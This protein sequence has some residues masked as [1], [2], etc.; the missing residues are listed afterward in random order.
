MIRRSLIGASL[1]AMAST[2]G[3]MPAL[4]RADIPLSVRNTFRIG[5]SGVICTAQNAPGDARLGG[6]FDRS[7]RLTC[8]D[9]AGAVGTLI[10]VHRELPLDGAPSA[11]GVPELACNV[12]AASLIDLVGAVSAQECRDQRSGVDY[13]RY[14]ARRDGVTYLVEGLAGY[15]PALRLALAS[16]VKDRSI[17]GEIRVASTEV[18]DPAAFARIQAG[19]L[20]SGGVREEAYLRNNGGHYAESAAFFE[21]LAER[22]EHKQAYTA[23]GIG[24]LAEALAS[25]ALQQSNMGN[26]DAAT[27]LFEASAKSISQGDVLTQRLLRNNRALDRL[28]QRDP[29]AAL[30]EIARPV[31]PV[32]AIFDR[33]KL[34]HGEI[35][36]PLSEQI[37]RENEVLKRLGGIDTGLSV[38]ERAAILDAQAVALSGTAA[39]LQGKFAD[40]AS[41]LDQADRTLASVHN[42][43]VVSVGWLRS[44]IAVETALVEEAQGQTGNAKASFDRAIAMLETAFPQSPALLAA[45]A[46]KAAFLGRIGAASEARTLFADVVKESASSGDSGVALRDLL[47]PYFRLLA[48]QGGADAATDAFAAAQVLQRPGVAQTQAVLAR[49]FAEG[50]DEASALFRLSLARTRD[51]VRSEGEIARL[52]GLAAP[53]PAELAQLQ[54]E[55]GQLVTLQ[56]DQTA[57]VSR[58]A[59]YPRYN[60]LSPQRVSLNELQQALKPG[61]AYYKLMVAGDEV[62]A[63]FA[64]PTA[65]QTFRINLSRDALADQVRNIRDTI[66][67]VE[68]GR[69][70]NYPFNVPLSRSL[71]RSLFD[72]LEAEMPNV[73]H[74]VFE[75]DGAML[76]LPPGVLIASDKGIAAY[77]RQ[78]AE[79]DGDPFDMTGIDWLG[80]NREISIA[81]SPRGFLDIRK[82]APSRAARPYLG[83][84]HNASPPAR[85]VTAAVAD[86]CDWPLATWQN[87]ISADELHFAQARMGPG[88]MVMT[89]GQFSDTMLLADPRLDQYRV[90]H[91][92]T[93]GLVTAPRKDCPARPA[94]ITSFGGSGSDGLLSFR[95][96]FDL[97]LDADVVIL[98]ACDTAGMATI[99]ASR[100]AGVTSGGNYALDGLVRAFVGSGARSVVASHWP[101][102]D[103]FDA[104]KRLIGGMVSA[105]PG[106]PLAEALMEA[107][108][109]LMNDPRTSHPFY[110]A[111][112]II[113]GDGAKPMIAD[114]TKVAVKFSPERTR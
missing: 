24:S 12:A 95:E 9:A 61:E 18:S 44:E 85:T 113:L 41:Q 94:L 10:A 105:I 2:L 19:Q 63:L 80:R 69:Q 109:K 77:T 15:D 37:N 91:F 4:A 8:R 73:R 87:P 22:D 67:K 7:Y 75:P 79:P 29:A 36:L 110:W 11:P 39:R 30:A 78:S 27:R 107:E 64:S 20:D 53:T 101:V 49:Q 71:Y 26:F 55:Q 42:G 92:A 58:L 34:A 62:Y 38:A 82:L 40:A 112:F 81:V 56:G 97:K 70:V 111:A 17:A 51:I 33:N 65:A 72:P 89:D 35:N 93:H 50:N 3:M 1:A 57:L 32:D 23:G 52:S 13:R 47:T 114:Q 76:Q 25:Q 48:Q 106:K 16:V 99:G 28:N 59:A 100:E 14:A 5:N 83:L 90:L 46:R 68:A 88:G 74:L 86:E 104:T 84:G 31:E 98:S 6:M 108:R 96:I 21:S 45:K 60:V 103:D 66:V 43:R 54:A 102:P